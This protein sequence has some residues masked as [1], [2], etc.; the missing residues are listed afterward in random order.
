MARFTHVVFDLDGTLLDTEGLY[1]AAT[2]EVAEVY[3][4][5]FPLELKRRCMGADNR[6]SAATIIAELGLPLS[7]DGFLALRDAAFER[8]LAQVQPIAGAAE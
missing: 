8:R 4:K 7:V 6:T 2:R 1:T 5:H 3:G